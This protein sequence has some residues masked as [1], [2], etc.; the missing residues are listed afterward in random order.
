MSSGLWDHLLEIIKIS[1]FFFF[2]LFKIRIL[3]Y[4]LEQQQINFNI[5]CVEFSQSTN[6]TNLIAY[7]KTEVIEVQFDS[8]VV[9]FFK[10][11]GI[12]LSQ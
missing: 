8:N 12:A 5:L 1:I 11:K 4:F 10:W 2:S 7:V 3:E 6:S 9:T